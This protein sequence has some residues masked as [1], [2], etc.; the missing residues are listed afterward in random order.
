M[1]LYMLTGV[2]PHKTAE[3]LRREISG[4][5]CC[6]CASGSDVAIVDVDEVCPAS[7]GSPTRT[8]NAT[9]NSQTASSWRAVCALT[10]ASR[11][12]LPANSARWQRS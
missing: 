6:G 4:V 3:D 5:G 1:L 10:R 8:S 7:Y 9:V 11:A 12:C 2:P